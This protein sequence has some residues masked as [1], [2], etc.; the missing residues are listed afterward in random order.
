M[1]TLATALATIAAT[2]AIAATGAGAQTSA[3]D[4]I[5]YCQGSADNGASGTISD[6]EH[7]VQVGDPPLPAGARQERVKVDGITTTVTEMG[8]PDASQAVVF[9]HGSPEYSRDFD[10]LLSEAGRYGRAI[11]FDWPGYGHADDPAGW[12]YNLDGAAKFFGDLMD[13]LGVRS[14]DLVMHDFGGPWALQWAVGHPDQLHSVLVIDS[15]VFIGYLG[16]PFALVWVTP[17]VGEASMMT[18]TRQT[19]MT[20]FVNPTPLPPDF[21]NR[22][23]DNYDRGTR[24]ALLR[25]YRDM[26]DR[27][28]DT[29]GRAQAAVLKKR[30]RPALVIWGDQDPYIPKDVAY[31][32]DQAFPG[33]QVDIIKG[34]GHWPFVDATQQVDDAAVPFFQR[35]AAHPAAG[36]TRASKVHRHGR[37]RHHRRHARR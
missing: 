11:S 25:Y 17:G 12:P 19:F 13:K 2:A 31:R 32:Q 21:V 36:P 26:K 27:G 1:R 7:D 37:H 30:V 23:Y 33:A 24:C 22:M 6:Q 8:S 5:F 16:H 4:P 9:A 15:G 20:A 10:H 18:T 34:A 3:D 14:V 35:V 29:V 28:A